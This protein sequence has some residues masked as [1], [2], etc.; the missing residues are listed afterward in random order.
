MSIQ[1]ALDAWNE[2]AARCGWPIVRRM[3]VERERRL[4][5]LIRGGLEDWREALA[6]AEASDFLCGRTQKSEK[7]AGWRFTIDAMLRETFFARVL[8]GVY[9]NREQAAVTFKSPETLLWEARLRA[10]KPGSMWLGIWGPRPED[11]G[12]EAPKA[13]LDGWHQRQRGM[14]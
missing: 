14:N 11:D 7:H 4:R 9:D 12:C 2:A 1:E 3:T 5:G 13:V 10:Y 8:E 6:K